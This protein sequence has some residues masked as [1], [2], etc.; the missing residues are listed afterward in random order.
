MAE[1]VVFSERD[2]TAFELLSGGKE[3]SQ[4]L[5]LKLAAAVFGENAR[6]RAIEYVSYGA[7]KVY[8]DEDALLTHFSVEPYAQALCEI[9][10]SHDVHFL[11]MGSSKRGKELAPRVSQKL[12]AGCITDAI[13][14]RV[15][16]GELV[17]DR[18]TLGGNAVASEV[19]KTPIKVVSVM[20][21]VFTLGEKEQRQGEIINIEPKLEQPRVKFID[22]KPKQAESVSLEEAERLVCIGRGLAQKDDLEIIEQLAGALNADIGCTRTLAADFQWLSEQR[23]VGLSGK[24]CRP[25]LNLSIGISGQIQHTVGILGS[26]IIVAINKDRNAPIFQVADYGIVG[27][28]YQVVPQITQR[29]K[30]IAG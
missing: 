1:M 4:A 29:I 17:V 27:D 7:E 16:N 26:K 15:T 20:P 19:V 18:Y 5:D 10:Q 30:G 6:E 14:I 8:L 3:F 11:L 13:G 12:D 2:E 25:K 23:V 9:A 21:G 28:L 22:S 24:K